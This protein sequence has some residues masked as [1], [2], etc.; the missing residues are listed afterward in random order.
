MIKTSTKT[1]TYKTDFPG[2]YVD[3]VTERKIYHAWLYHETIG[4][5]KYMF[6]INRKDYSMEDML[7]MVEAALNN[8]LY[9]E[10]YAEDY[11][12]D[13]IPEEEG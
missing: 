8:Q 5:K 3:I 2:F 6:G 11:M 13:I 10:N 12:S 7:D 9:I 4:I 1:T